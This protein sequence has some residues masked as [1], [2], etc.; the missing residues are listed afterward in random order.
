MVSGPLHCDAEGFAIIDGL[1]AAKYR[2]NV[3]QSRFNA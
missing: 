2:K 1:D 3:T